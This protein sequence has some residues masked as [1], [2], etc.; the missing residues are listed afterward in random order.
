M[1]DVA[2]NTVDATQRSPPWTSHARLGTGAPGQRVLLDRAPVADGAI[3]ATGLEADGPHEWRV[4]S[5]LDAA[6]PDERVF[7][8]EPQTGTLAFGD[9]RRG[10]PLPA[11]VEL[12]AR[13]D[14][15]LAA[16]GTLAPG[17]TLTW[18]TTRATPR[19]S[20]VIRPPPQR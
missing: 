7:E 15:T 5:T 6:A 2:V 9:G 16:R 13:Y 11:D 10:R 1:L 20:G 8:L 4:I 19:C 3:A 14:V 12:H 18:P 17:T